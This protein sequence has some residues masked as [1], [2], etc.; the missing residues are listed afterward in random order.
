M[1]LYGAMVLFRSASSVSQ[2]TPGS[3]RYLLR[4]CSRF[5]VE[6]VPPS[7]KGLW[8]LHFTYGA[9]PGNLFLFADR[10]HRYDKVVISEINK[11]SPSDFTKLVRSVDNATDGSHYLISTGPLSSDRTMSERKVA[12]SYILGECCKKI[13]GDRVEEIKKLYDT[14]RNEPTTSTTARMIFQYR[15]HQFLQ[16]GRVLE[17]LPLLGRN[18]PE[19]EGI[20]Y[21]DYASRN[22]KHASLPKLKERV[23]TDETGTRLGYDTYYRPQ[24][25]SFPT[26]DSWVLVQHH[27]HD[28]PTFLTF[29]I[30]TDMEQHEVKRSG[31]DKVDKLDIPFGA[32]RYLVVLTPTGVKPKVTVPMDYLTDKFSRGYGVDM[33]SKFL[34]FHYQVDNNVLFGPRTS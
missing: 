8:Y 31:L 10:P 4:F 33:A 20:I 12:S 3:Q 24:S 19:G 28:T 21:E 17:F 16:M 5:L 7:E 14:L 6:S 2:S 26:I 11:L 34:V 15:A 18:S 1:A 25:N 9:S 30:T 29:Q 13:F 23:V 27:P 32:R 22:P